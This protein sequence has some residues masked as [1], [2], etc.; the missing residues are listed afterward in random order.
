MTRFQEIKRKAVE[1]LA[2]MQ[3]DLAPSNTEIDAMIIAA[4]SG[5]RREE[6]GE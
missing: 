3:T 1:L 4:L 5:P 6:T 2:Q